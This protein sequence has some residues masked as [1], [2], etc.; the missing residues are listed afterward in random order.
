MLL[1]VMAFSVY[2]ATE[3]PNRKLVSML[4]AYVF[5]MNHSF[6]IY[7]MVPHKDRICDVPCSSVDEQR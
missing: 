6:R 5:Y 4:P 7:F 1:F 3:N 2:F